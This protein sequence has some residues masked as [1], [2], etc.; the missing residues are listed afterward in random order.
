MLQKKTLRD[1]ISNTT[2]GVL[3]QLHVT[4]RKVTEK[5]IKN[6]NENI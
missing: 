3:M 6:R 2:H 5:V 1:N 4:Q